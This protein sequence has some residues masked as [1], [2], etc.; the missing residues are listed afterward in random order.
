MLCVYMP[1][2]HLYVFPVL[3]IYP[4]PRFTHS[5]TSNYII[6][7]S[8]SRLKAFEDFE[9]D[10]VIAS[11]KFDSPLIYFTFTISLHLYACQKHIISIIR[12]FSYIIPNLTKH[13]YNNLKF[14]QRI[15]GKLILKTLSI[16]N[17]IKAFMS[18]P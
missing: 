4:Y 6:F 5:S 10:F 16:I 18:N 3:I 11:T 8:T 15:K 17:L 1:L 12:R 14:I 7:V 2:L 13:L 9:F